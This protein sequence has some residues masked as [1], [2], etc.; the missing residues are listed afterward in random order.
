MSLSIVPLVQCYYT[1]EKGY[2]TYMTD[3]GK[4]I[5]RPFVVWF[6]EGASRNIIVD[7]GIDVADYLNYHPGFKD[8]Q[9]TKV[10]DFPEALASVGITPD[11]VDLVIQTHLHFDHCYNLR[12]C[13]NAQVMVQRA[14]YEYAMD[15]TPY[16]GIYRPEL[17]EGV[18]FTFIDGEYQVEPGLSLLPVPGHTAGGQAVLVD[19]KDGVVAIAG[20]CSCRENFYPAAGHPMVGDDDVLLPGII[21]QAREAYE[22]MK[23]L[24][25]KADRI[26]AL[27]DP[28]IMD[29]KV[30]G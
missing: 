21:W 22:S 16:E 15:P 4:P 1:A 28:D 7:S 11:Q 17:W 20:M 25:A 13:T 26:L 29:E 2:M 12:R 14:E 5:V 23:L 27:H 19:T 30:I 9:M 3:Y 10:Q 8:L 18:D 24:Q 6:I